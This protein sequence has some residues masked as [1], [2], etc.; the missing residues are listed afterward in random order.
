M[1]AMMEMMHVA[2]KLVGSHLAVVCFWNIDAA[3]SAIIQT[4]RM[5]YHLISVPCCV[6]HMLCHI[7]HML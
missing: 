3:A 6:L 5:T 2:C 4:S 7:M 1:P